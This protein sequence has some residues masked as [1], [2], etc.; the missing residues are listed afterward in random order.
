MFSEFIFSELCIQTS[1]TIYDT[2]G[3]CPGEGYGASCVR[4]YC[5]PNLY[6]LNQ[7]LKFLYKKKLLPIEQLYRAHLKCASMARYVAV[8]RYIYEHEIV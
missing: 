7:E 3:S 6:R 1:V 5:T 8:C 4:V 2:T